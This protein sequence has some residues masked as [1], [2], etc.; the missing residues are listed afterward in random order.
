[1]EGSWKPSREGAGSA[2]L[3]LGSRLGSFRFGRLLSELAGHGPGRGCCGDVLGRLSGNGSEVHRA[4]GGY[5][6]RIDAELA[7]HCRCGRCGGLP[8][9]RSGCGVRASYRHGARTRH[10]AAAA[11]GLLLHGQ[12][13]RKGRRPHDGR[14]GRLGHLVGGV[15]QA[16]AH[17]MAA[18]LHGAE[19]R[20]G[21]VRRLG[22]QVGLVA[23]AHLLDEGRDRKA[24]DDDAAQG[25]AQKQDGRDDA[26]EQGEAHPGERRAHIAS[27]G[28]ERIVVEQVLGPGVA[29]GREQRDDAEQRHQDERKAHGDAQR[30]ALA[31]LAVEHGRAHGHEE[32]RH[33]VA[34]HPEHEVERFGQKRGDDGAGRGHRCD[35]QHDADEDEAHTYHVATGA[36]IQ[37]AGLGLDSA[38]ARRR[39]G[40][41]RTALRDRSARVFR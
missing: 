11:A 24:N 19:E 18:A 28:R 41:A 8:R 1:M 33:D 37:N 16:V 12:A 14:I 21:Q 3:G 39:Q 32:E 26:A 15:S 35:E 5:G 23:L 40:T 29:E 4:A 7:G 6:R 22:G 10:R 9:S 20:L 27:V 38:A 25:H 2:A 36:V 17:D 13:R 34:A 30:H 31:L